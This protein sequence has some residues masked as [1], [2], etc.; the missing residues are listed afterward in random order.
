MS[1]LLLTSILNQ[2]KPLNSCVTK[3]NAIN[4]NIFNDMLIKRHL[5][6]LG[7]QSKCLSLDSSESNL[8]KELAK[9]FEEVNQSIEESKTKIV[10][11]DSCVQKLKKVIDNKDDM[12]R[13]EVFSGGCSGLQYKFDICQKS[14]ADDHIFER[15]GVR[16]V[17]DSDSLQFINGSTVDY[18][19]ELIKSS[20]RV[21]NN[22]Q[23]EQG[24]SCGA[25]FAIKLDTGF[26]FKP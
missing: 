17:V 15:D 24:C 16:V 23:S 25:S 22:P 13:V 18:N 9:D 7:I 20:F 4:G 14:E 10:I 5:V 11:S 3:M 12:L 2:M 8:T 1:R 21:I 6:S 19:E 26:K